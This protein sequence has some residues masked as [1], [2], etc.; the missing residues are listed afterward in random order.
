MRSIKEKLR[1]AEI[2]ELQS[3]AEQPSSEPG[4]EAPHEGDSG[5]YVFC[6]ECGQNTFREEH[7]AVMCSN[8][9]HGP[10]CNYCWNVHLR[11][12]HPTLV[13]AYEDQRRGI[14]RRARL[15]N[16]YLVRAAW[17]PVATAG[18]LAALMFAAYIGLRDREGSDEGNLAAKVAV[19]ESLVPSSPAL[20][21]QPPGPHAD[22]ATA[23]S[24]P[25]SPRPP[26]SLV[27]GRTAS[28]PA[29]S[30]SGSGLIQLVKITSPIIRGNTASLTVSTASGAACTIE[31]RYSS[32]P[33]RA[34][35]LEPARAGPSGRITWSWRVSQRTT[36]GD[37]P[38][39]VTCL[40]GEQ[41]DALETSVRV[42]E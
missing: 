9:S 7:N 23:L 5:V 13:P 4:P 11:E 32:G 26:Q 17:K 18:A 25:Q 21:E 15:R 35:G 29:A 14:R 19:D 3:L 24:E 1:Q 28:T 40:M 42:V 38:V 36:P 8:C 10:F 2:E 41:D 33:S 6:A 30:K 31:V 16:H 27:A 20:A 37:W 39:R 34:K 22:P 12:F